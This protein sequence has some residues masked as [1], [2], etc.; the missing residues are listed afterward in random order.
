M[1]V[2]LSAR[3][4]LGPSRDDEA[5]SPT[6][7]R[8]IVAIDLAR[9][10]GG[11]AARRAGS[12]LA[13]STSHEPHV[14]RRPRRST[15]ALLHRRLLLERHRPGAARRGPPCLC[16]P[17]RCALPSHPPSRSD[18]ASRVRGGEASR[19]S[20]A[21][22]HSRSTSGRRPRA[23]SPWRCPRRPARPRPRLAPR[24]PGAGTS[25][26]YL[27]FAGAAER[28]WRR[29]VAARGVDSGRRDGARP[30]RTIALPHARRRGRLQRGRACEPTAS[31]PADRELGRVGGRV[32]GALSA[33]RER[34]R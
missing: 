9:L 22:A 2:N 7:S 25:G 21:R 8:H 1:C 24:A 26:S 3:T 16:G 32:D 19:C 23:A 31:R 27:G 20:R 18:R 10:L 29:K 33:R 30:D 34:G 6:K 17:R 4:T 15:C 11:V 14:P 12:T 5:S 28:G 13:L